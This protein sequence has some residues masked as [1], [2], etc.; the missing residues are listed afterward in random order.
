MVRHLLRTAVALALMFA[1]VLLPRPARAAETQV[2][3]DPAGR[4]QRIDETLARRIGLFVDKYPG[5]QEARLFM[6]SDSTFVL[7]VSM[8]RGGQLQRERENLTREQAD[9]LR[10]DIVQ[11]TAT[12]VSL[13][14]KPNQDGRALLMTG[15]ALLGLGFYGWAVPYVFDAQDG[16]VILGSYML[17]AGSSF[18]LPMYLTRNA[19]VTWGMANLSLYGATRGIVHGVLIHQAL[20]PDA[21]EDG[22]EQVATAMVTSLTEGALGYAIAR[23]S[24]M[25]AGSSM[26][27]QNG[28]DY[29]LLWG[30]LV[31]DIAGT[32]DGVADRSVAL[33]MLGTSAAGMVGGGILAGHRAYSYGDGLVM[34]SSGYVGML[35]ATAIVDAGQQNG[36]DYS[37]AYSGGLLAGS[38]AGLLIGDRLVARRE[39]TVGD[40]VLVQVGGAFGALMGLG[41][42]AISNP[43]GDNSTAYWAGTAIGGTLGY[44]LTYAQLSKKAAARASDRSSWRFE[45]APEGMLAA[46][47][48]TPGHAST[49]T[50]RPAPTLVRVSCTF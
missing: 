20:H 30:Y 12:M 29:G 6:A 25:S 27:I 10:A 16:S 9:A 19:S 41:A 24:R 47:G 33:T 14:E 48:R 5:F 15:S 11:R 36:S 34:R 44:A 7:E 45:I 49:H 4:I 18:F 21:F 2:A 13:P 1:A 31:S 17:T 50:A 37:K 8:L 26:A 38:A 40:G 22:Q 35:V 23:Q 43:Q 39:F 28:G 46:M 32:T 3:F 42:V